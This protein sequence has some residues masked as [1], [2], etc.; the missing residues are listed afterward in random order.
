MTEYETRI[1]ILI[2]RLST[3]V[4][5]YNFI[6][7]RHLAIGAEHNTYAC[8]YGLIP[9]LSTFNS[10]ASFPALSLPPLNVC[11]N[12]PGMSFLKCDNIHDYTSVIGLLLPF[13]AEQNLTCDTKQSSTSER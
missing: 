12:N 13:P 7:Y 6:P 1:S 3:A 2:P 4:W 5:I 10:L 9:R 11:G 8:L